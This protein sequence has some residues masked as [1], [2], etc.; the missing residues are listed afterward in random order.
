MPTDTLDL[1]RR[2]RKRSYFVTADLP[3]ASLAQTTVV[4]D[5]SPGAGLKGILPISGGDEGGEGGEDSDD[6]DHQRVRYSVLQKFLDRK[7]AA[8]ECL[9]SCAEFMSSAFEPYFSDAKD[10]MDRMSDHFQP[11]MRQSA[12]RGHENF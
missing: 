2:A 1:I 9:G 7:V 8:A 10:T 3:L 12:I 6:D 4:S 11:D 5:D